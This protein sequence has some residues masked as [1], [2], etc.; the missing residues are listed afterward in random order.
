MSLTFEFTM[1]PR[2]SLE[3]SPA[4]IAFGELLMLP[5]AALQAVIDDELRTNADLER[6]EPGD[7]P[8]CRGSWRSRCPVCAVPAHRSAGPDHRDVC[9]EVPAAESDCQALRRAVRAETSSADA[10]AVDYL[11]DSLDHH[12]LL[13]RSYA[14]L[15]ADLG[16]A[17]QE[18]VRLVEVIRRCGPPGIGATGAGECLLLQ[19]EAL[20][21]PDDQARLA[22]AVIADHLPALARGHFAAIADLLGTTRDQVRGVLDL[23]RRR[24]RPYPAFDGNDTAAPAYVVPDLVIRADPRRPGGFVVELVEAATTRLRGPPRRGRDAWQARS[25]LAQLR[26]RWETLRRIAEYVADRQQ[27][28]LAGGATALRPLTRAEVAWGL[29]LHESTVSRAV[30]DKYVLLPDRILVALSRFFGS[31]RCA[32][33]RNCGGCS[34]PAAAG[35]PTS[36]SPICCGTPVIRWPA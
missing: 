36:S 22:R 16:I 35:S 34:S 4:L 23:I 10:A 2:L 30:A 7:C 1:A 13:D 27:A 24:L 29:D 11:I 19:L 5:Y 8:V 12:G 6:L 15:A 31:S 18:V 17:E 20:H 9:A 32:L 21:L 3:V 25:F 26:D 33:M 14:D 28:F